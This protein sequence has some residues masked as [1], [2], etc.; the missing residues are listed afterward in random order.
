MRSSDRGCGPQLFFILANPAYGFAIWTSFPLSPRLPSALTF[1]FWTSIHGLA[2]LGTTGCRH[3]SSGV[4]RD[5]ARLAA[6]DCDRNVV[7]YPTADYL[8][9]IRGSQTFGGC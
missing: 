9:D 8:S 1:A 6:L 3:V 7:P 2:A 5:V 4:S